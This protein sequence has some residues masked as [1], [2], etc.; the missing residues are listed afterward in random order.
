MGGGLTHE[1]VQGELSSEFSS[2][3]SPSSRCSFGQ[4]QQ[5]RADFAISRQGTAFP[6]KPPGPQEISQQQITSGNVASNTSAIALVDKNRC[7]KSRANIDGPL[8]PMLDAPRSFDNVIC[9]LRRQ[10]AAVTAEVRVEGRQRLHSTASAHLLWALPKPRL[11]D[12]CPCADP[13]R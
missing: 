7:S 3:Q 10:A 13:R 1:K 6:T 12:G 5:L 2:G 8:H 9:G 4:Q 11:S